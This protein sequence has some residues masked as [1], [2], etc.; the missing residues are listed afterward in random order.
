MRAGSRQS[1]QRLTVV[2]FVRHCEQLALV[3]WLDAE[4]VVIEI[5]R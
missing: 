5:P 1:V 4:W 3:I 2:L